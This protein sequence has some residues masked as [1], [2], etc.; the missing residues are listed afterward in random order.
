MIAIHLGIG[1]LDPEFNSL[2]TTRQTSSRVTSV[3]QNKLN[4]AEKKAVGAKTRKL[5]ISSNTRGIRVFSMVEMTG[6]ELT[7]SQVLIWG[8]SN[9]AKSD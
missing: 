7:F 1:S 6:V 4:Y 5:L 8:L 2:R 9:Q 3:S